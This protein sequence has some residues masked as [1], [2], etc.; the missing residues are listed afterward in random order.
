MD[1]R[2]ITP[3]LAIAGQPTKDDLQALKDAG[4]VG[5]VNLRNDNEPE[6]V[7]ST[8]AEG[9]AVKALGMDYLHQ[10]FGGTP[11]STPAVANVCDF[12]DRHSDGKV[13]VHCRSGG[14]AAALVLLQQAR[15]HRWPADE[16]ISQG[17]ALGLELSPPL[18]M[19]VEQFFMW[20]PGF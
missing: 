9:E 4:Y 12:L 1:V 19:M 15:A 5:V 18:K 8:S 17:K 7:L 6:Q 20:N 10:G 2:T 11:F 3:N 14:R 13:L 16:A